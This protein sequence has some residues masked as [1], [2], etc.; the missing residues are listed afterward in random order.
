[1]LMYKILRSVLVFLEKH[2]IDC[3]AD[4]VLRIIK[5]IYI[6]KKCNV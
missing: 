6:D 5:K 4:F 1:M 3:F 2:K